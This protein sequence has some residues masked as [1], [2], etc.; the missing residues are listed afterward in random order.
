[1]DRDE[2]GQLAVLMVGVGVCAHHWVSPSHKGYDWDLALGV[3]L[4]ILFLLING[5]TDE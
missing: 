3:I 1:V 5:R 2:L 4:I